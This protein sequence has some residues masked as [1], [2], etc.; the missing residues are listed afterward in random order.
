MTTLVT[1]GRA[2]VEAIRA[3]HAVARA[4]VTAERVDGRRTLEARVVPWHTAARVTDDGRT[5][6]RETWEPGS[7]IPDTRVPVYNGHIPGGGG[8]GRLNPDRELIGRADNFRTEADGFYATITLVDDAAA[9]RVYDVA[10]LFG[11]LD[12]SLEADVPA[13]ASGTVARTAAAP[14]LLTGLAVVLPPGSGAFP[15][16]MATAAR[17]DAGTDDDDDDET[18]DDGDDEN[19]DTGTDPPPAGAGRAGVTRGELAEAVRAEVVRLN[20]SGQRDRVGRGGPWARFRSFDEVIDVA[21][22]GRRQAAAEVSRQFAE[23]Y[24]AWSVAR[25]ADMVAARVG[26]ALVDQVPADNPG[27]MPPSWLSEVFGIVDQGRPG[28]V[29]FGGARSPGDSGLDVYWPYY[30]GDLRAIVA[31]QTAPKAPINS[32]KVSFKRGQATLATYAGGSDVAYQLQ[33]R[34]TPAYMSLYDR[35]LQIA[36][37]LT[38]ENAFVDAVQTAAGSDMTYDGTADTDGSAAKAVLFA[39]SAQVKRVTG[40]P[41]TAA[42]AASDVYAALGG[43]PWLQPP[44]YGTQN[45]PGT[46]SASTLSI[47]ISGLTITEAPD[48]AAGHLLV[49]NDSAAAWLEDGPFLVR[50]E[51]VE[52]LGTDVAIWGMGAAAIFLPAGVVDITVTVPPPLEL[53]ARTP[54]KSSK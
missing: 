45:V 14:V 46:A 40:T 1:V 13:G 9:R 39:A 23:T 24:Q 34:S 11:E 26:R 3:T 20:I 44:Q 41:A 49:S 43:M 21:R 6:Y 17:S 10:D 32:V 28:I 37:G 15:G 52:K 29:A 42:L 16:A 5:F 51:D 12:V 2:T 18:D 4:S 19:G 25:R 36:F 50:A 47:N 22:G 53:A 8:P 7:L 48:L 38:T 33:R 27:L 31:A 30:D 54:A 35:I